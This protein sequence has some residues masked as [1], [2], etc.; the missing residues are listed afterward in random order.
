MRIEEDQV[1]ASIVVRF[2]RKYDKRILAD[3]FHL[4]AQMC[5]SDDYEK[6]D[7]FECLS[8]LASFM[9]EDE[10]VYHAPYVEAGV[11]RNDV[12]AQLGLSNQGDTAT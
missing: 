1:L 3:M 9:Y 8:S 10:Y 4:A 6:C 12:I 11:R 5:W 7:E 2:W